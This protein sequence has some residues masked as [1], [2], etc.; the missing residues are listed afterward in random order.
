ML[1]PES[2]VR[3]HGFAVLAAFVAINTVVYVALSVAKALPKVYVRDHLPR[4]YHRAET[5]SIHPDAP[6]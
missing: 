3:S 4:T 6:R 5:R 2:L 1:L